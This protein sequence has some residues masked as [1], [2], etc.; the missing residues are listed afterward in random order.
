MSL[1]AT[2]FRWKPIRNNVTVGSESLPKIVKKS[3][4][5][6]ESDRLKKQGLELKQAIKKSVMGT[7]EPYPGG[8]IFIFTRFFECV[9]SGA[10]LRGCMG[11]RHTTG[12][13]PSGTDESFRYSLI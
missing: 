12:I 9:L 2:N 6:G 13:P 11:L 3:C 5:C 1:V 10:P 7:R 4:G 8:W